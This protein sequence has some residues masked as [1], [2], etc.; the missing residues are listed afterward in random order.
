MMRMT[1]LTSIAGGAALAAAS[2]A[3]AQAGGPPASVPQGGPRAEDIAAANRQIDNDY[4]TL[5]GRGVKVNNQDRANS[6]APKR[7]TVR[8]ATAEDIQAGARVRDVKDVPVGTIA[9][10][11][12]NEVVADPNQVVIDTGQTKIGVPLAAFGKDD[13]GLLLSITADKFNQ[14]VAQAHANKPAAQSN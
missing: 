6:K 3:G 7:A 9:S 11:G 13:K 10:L 5:A 14:L 12:A 4:N 1:I 2:I 8:P